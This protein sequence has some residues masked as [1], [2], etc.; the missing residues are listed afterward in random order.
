MA[1]LKRVRVMAA[2]VETTAGTAESLDAGDGSFTAWDI[3]PQASIPVEE[4]EGQGSFNYLA[5][6]PGG[7]TGTVAFKTDIAWDGTATLPTWATVLLAGCGWVNASGTVTPRSEAPGSNVKTLTIGVYENGM[8]KTLAGCMGS[9][10]IV[11][12]TGRNV[13]IEWSFTGVWQAPTDTAIIAPTYPT[14]SAIRY[15]TAP[16]TWNSVNLAV[17]QVT[18]DSGNEVILKESPATAAGFSHAIVTSRRPMISCNPEA[19]LVATLDVY[20]A[21]LA[22]TE[23]AFSCT[24]DTP[25]NSALVISAPKAQIVNVQESDRGKVQIHDLEFS[26]N[27]NGTAADQELSLVFTAAV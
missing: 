2:A 20:G 14:A 19:V 5:G 13:F 27:K 24:L 21:W 8:L 22:Q 10:R 18:F 25:S 3:L 17:E 26:C 9:F 15:A 23:A 4:R 11:C 16:T 1:L 6:V 7:R 12:P